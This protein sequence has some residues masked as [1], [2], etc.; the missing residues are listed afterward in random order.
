MS[1]RFGVLSVQLGLLRC[2]GHAGFMQCSV[3]CGVVF[4]FDVRQIVS[5]R[6]STRFE[7]QGNLVQQD[8][9]GPKPWTPMVPW[10][11]VLVWKLSHVHSFGNSLAAFLAPTLKLPLE[12]LL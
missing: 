1:L 8:S 3:L 5:H 12:L 6:F 2:V 7:R 11:R 4:L 9:E 10:F